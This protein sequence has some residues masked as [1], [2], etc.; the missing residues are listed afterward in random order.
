MSDPQKLITAYL[1]DTL[2]NAERD[3][4]A[5]WLK[6]HPDHLRTFV[7]A[8]LFEQQIRSAVGGQIQREAAS[9][10]IESGILPR[11]TP[12]H[13][14]A[15]SQRPWF[16]RLWPRLATASAAILALALVG[17]SLWLQHPPV[18]ASS[19]LARVT[20]LQSAQVP[21]QAAAFQTGQKLEP[22]R[23]T[24]VAGAVEISLSNGV[25]IVF[26]GPG[27]IELLTPM[28]ILLHAGQA[29]VRVPKNAR[30]FQLETPGASLVDMGTEFGMKAGPGSSTDVQVYEGV[31][32]TTPKSANAAG[33]FPQ[34]LT[35]GNA[36]RYSPDTQMVAQPMA[37]APER[38]LRSLPADQPIEFKDGDPNQYNRSRF[39]EILIT[40]PSQPVVVD[41]D[42]S[43]WSADGVFRSEG[44]ETPGNEYYVEGRMR[45]DA[46]YLYIGAHIGDPMPMRNVINPATDGEFGWRGGGLQVRVSTERKTSWPANGNAPCYYKFRNL[47]I[48]TN[49]MVQATSDSLAHLT[50]WRCMPTAQNCLHAAYGMDFHSGTVNP[51]G[52]RGAFRKDADGRGYTLEYAIPWSLLHAEG[53]PPRAGDT[54]AVS[55]T[56][57]WS[58]DSGRLWRGQHTE[59]RNATEPLRIQPWERAA[60]WGR[61][62]YR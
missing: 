17:V 27:E 50:L 3:E 52:Y 15:D 33:S 38:F 58:D 20:R 43:E 21:A 62:V 40:P 25:T 42:L 60:T 26:E 18:A 19:G 30:G 8:N 10:L 45:Y 32:I 1:D 16:Y 61:A 9:N 54:L 23:L 5:A 34:R 56:A 2:T 4:L 55:W 31:V 22:G 47:P 28:R 13:V 44:S 29:V 37:Y 24:L 6:A 39:D 46:D 48:D 36:A 53:D 57:H 41:G 49:Q 12:Q 14:A 11:Q 7:E 59:I 35:A 51:P